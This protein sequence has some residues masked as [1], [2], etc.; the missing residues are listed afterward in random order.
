[1]AVTAQLP[2]NELPDR[3]EA[4]RGKDEMASIPTA[5]ADASAVIRVMRDLRKF[6]KDTLVAAFVWLN[7]W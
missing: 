5:R 7:F 6:E 3:S 2:T 4:L 1:V